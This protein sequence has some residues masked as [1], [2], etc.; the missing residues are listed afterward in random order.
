MDS[1]LTAKPLITRAH[2]NVYGAEGSAAYNVM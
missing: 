2:L 1:T